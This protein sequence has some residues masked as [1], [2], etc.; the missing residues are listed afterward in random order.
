V[1]LPELVTFSTTMDYPLPNPRYLEVH[2]TCAKVCYYSGAGLYVNEIIQELKESP[3]LASDG[4][5]YEILKFA[6]DNAILTF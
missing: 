6:L 1:Q 3:F 4:T 5:S 2:A